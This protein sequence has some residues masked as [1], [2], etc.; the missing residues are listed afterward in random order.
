[1][2]YRII[3]EQVNYQYPGQKE[4]ALDNI[5]ITI[6][7]STITGIIGPNGA[8]KT[9]LLKIIGLLYQPTNGSVL[10]ENKDPWSDPALLA[11]MRKQV[12][13]VHEKPVMIRGTVWDNLI[14]PLKI[15]EIPISRAKEKITHITR[16]LE[17]TKLLDKNARKLSTGQKQLVGIA[18]ALI[19]DPQVLVLDEPFSNLDYNRKKLLGQLL[20]DLA[21]QGRT[22]VFAS[23]D[24]LT[25]EVISNTLIVLD[26]GKVVIHGEPKNIIQKLY[27]T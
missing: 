18:R 25:T 26:N 16:I 27:N 12:V 8:G 20:K 21:S 9:T 6:N 7:P 10:I 22:I 24:T 13:Y 3:L 5:S 11:A 2:G 19:V 15:R 4:K 23:H 14:Y 17:L 1:M